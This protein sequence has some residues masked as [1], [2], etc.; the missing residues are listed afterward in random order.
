[1]LTVYGTENGCLIEH[2]RV[3]AVD[4]LR[5]AVWLDMVEPSAEEEKDV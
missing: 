2:P 3:E 4:A 5:A 1:M